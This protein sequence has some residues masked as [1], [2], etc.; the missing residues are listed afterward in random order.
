MTCDR[1]TIDGGW[2][3]VVFAA[4]LDDDGCCPCG[5]DYI[6]CECPGPTEDGI[7]YQE[8]EG[9]MYGRPE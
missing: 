1:K 3:E 5:I 8:V 2:R 4:D 7:E 6:D 9:V